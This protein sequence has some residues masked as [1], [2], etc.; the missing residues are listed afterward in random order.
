M[1]TQFT[2]SWYFSLIIALLFPSA[3]YPSH[4]LTAFDPNAAPWI[5]IALS[6]GGLRAAAF[7]HGVMLELRKLCLTADPSVRRP[8]QNKPYSLRYLEDKEYSDNDHSSPCGTGGR[9]SFLDNADFISAVSG[10]A[11]TASYYKTHPDRLNE[12]GQKLKDAQL[13]WRLLTGKKKT[14][15]WRPPLMLFAS[16]FDTIFQTFKLPVVPIPEFEVTPFATM[17]LYNGLFEGEQLIRVYNDLFLHEHTFGDLEKQELQSIPTLAGAL[18]AGEG[19]KRNGIGRAHLLINATD[20]ANGRVLTFDKE[21]FACLGDVE[22]F[23]KLDLATAVAASSTLPGVFSPLRLKS[24]VTVAD[25]KS[26]PTTCPLILGD[27][28]RSPVLVDGGVSDNLGV[29]GL[30]RKVFARKNRDTFQD[31]D[32]RLADGQYLEVDSDETSI[33]SLSSKK[34]KELK[35]AQVNPRSQKVFLLIVNAGVTATSSLPGLAGHLDNSFDVLIRD[36]TDLSRIVAQQLLD[37]FGFGTVELNLRDL[38][39]NNRVVTRIVKK[40]LEMQMRTSS[41]TDSV[42]EIAQAFD[43][44]EMERKVLNDLNSVSL[45]PSQD[46]TD[47]LILAGR[48][49]VAEMASQIIQE[50]EKLVDKK[51]SPSCDSIA[52]P[53]RYYCWPSS[54]ETP[55]LVANKIGVFLDVLT[56]TADNYSKVVAENH[57]AQL[58]QVKIRLRNLYANEARALDLLEAYGATSQYPKFNLIVCRHQQDALLKQALRV[59]SLKDSFPKCDAREGLTDVDKNKGTGD[60]PKPDWLEIGDE[61]KS[62]KKEKIDSYISAWL[63]PDTSS[64]DIVKIKSDYKIDEWANNYISNLEKYEST[65][66]GTVPPWKESPWYDYLLGRFSML[67]QRPIT[68]F[69]HLYRGATAFPDEYNLSYLL[70]LYSIQI[71]HDFYGGLRHLSSAIEKAQTKRKQIE[72]L[73]AKGNSALKQTKE[74]ARSRFLRAED[75]YLLQ[76]AK[77][78]ALSPPSSFPGRSEFVSDSDVNSWLNQTVPDGHGGNSFATLLRF[79]QGSIGTKKT[80]LQGP[81]C[82]IADLLKIENSKQPITLSLTQSIREA[83]KAFL[84]HYKEILDPCPSDDETNVDYQPSHQE[85]SYVRNDPCGDDDIEKVDMSPEITPAMLGF[86]ACRDYTRIR[87]AVRDLLSPKTALVYARAQAQRLYE[88]SPSGDQVGHFP[89]IWERA[90]VY[91][92]TVLIDAIQTDC[93]HRTQDLGTAK[94]LFHVAKA[95]VIKD[96]RLTVDDDFVKGVRARIK[97]LIQIARDMSCGREVTLTSSP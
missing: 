29:T 14:P 23:R 81:Y 20:I 75:K 69:Q 68:G 53:V 72:G 15:F 59:D 18:F 30:L 77:Y 90:D 28:V 25:A 7:S 92:L 33:S 10:G 12:F 9:A 27:Q 56:K 49:V 42:H 39:K 41:T 86:D 13:E 74:I 47:T 5:G 4:D 24:Y 79:A 6:G 82:R 3:A 62:Y 83:I 1:R 31:T 60:L 51:Y 88:E 26:I 52:N 96:D 55:Q 46:E 35:T 40:S 67:Q 2:S 76:F 17:A 22:G 8:E 63:N 48:A 89:D 66:G 80:I 50:Y 85:A 87:H 45:L 70:G 61:I 16:L 11:I 44:T 34:P 21:T 65:A 97:I 19:N 64:E 94:R 36:R 54:F 95:A 84:D 43:F 57:S 78:L 71:N 32:S 91:G 37:N 58:D 93:P 73:D 38:V